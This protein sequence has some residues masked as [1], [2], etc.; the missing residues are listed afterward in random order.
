MGIGLEN[1]SE[2]KIE[3]GGSA[4]NSNATRGNKGYLGDMTV[5]PSFKELAPIHG[6]SYFLPRQVSSNRSEV[7]GPRC[8][9]M[10][11]FYE[12]SD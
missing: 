6:K 4:L 10:K 2:T 9:E 7:V 8:C 5:V 3:A 11:N 1:T 12:Q